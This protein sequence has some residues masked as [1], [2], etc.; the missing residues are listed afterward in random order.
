[1]IVIKSELL[2][3]FRRFSVSE[4]TTFS[5]LVQLLNKFYVLQETNYNVKYID[6]DG[7]DIRITS[8]EELVEAFR[9]NPKLLRIRVDK[10]LVKP[11]WISGI[12]V[13]PSVNV[14]EARSKF[15]DFKKTKVVTSP[16]PQESK[17]SVQET[18]ESQE[19]VNNGQIE[20][21]AEV[22][23]TPKE[24][25][26]EIKNS[27]TQEIQESQQL[28]NRTIAD[29]CYKNSDSIKKN[30]DQIS[31][32]VANECSTL[33]QNT[34]VDC[35]QL[36]ARSV[37]SCDPSLMNTLSDLSNTA[38]KDCSGLVRSTVHS[39]MKS[40]EQTLATSLQHSKDILLLI[41]PL[42]NLTVKSQD[43]AIATMSHTFKSQLH[44]TL[45][46]LSKDS[47]TILS[48]VSPISRETVRLQDESLRKMRES[49]M[50]DVA[51]VVSSTISV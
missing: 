45:S 26:E 14:E 41:A 9:T 11:V 38:K 35:Q 7:D 30:L 8:D 42:S 47:N 5:E 36:C 10:I 13:V 6:E 1:M 51:R 37:V 25:E 39:S 46:D 24:V 31:S 18:Q 29:I 34:A 21:P 49:M 4:T 33:S 22:L 50:A 48:Q 27:S 17:V 32:N 16:E 3:D 43:E 19:C 40:N 23:E 12:A 2:G 44:T 28:I 20:T 15:D